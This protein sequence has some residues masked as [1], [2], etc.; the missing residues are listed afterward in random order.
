MSPKPLPEIVLRP[1]TAADAPACGQIY[2]D[3]FTPSTRLTFPPDFPSPEVAA[4]M[5]SW[6]RQVQAAFHKRSASLY[7]GLG[8]DIREPTAA[9]RK[10]GAFLFVR[11]P[12]S[13]EIAA[14]R[15][16][17][18]VIC[19]HGFSSDRRSAGGARA[20]IDNF[21]ASNG[22]DDRIRAAGFGRGG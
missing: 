19:N 15:P 18:S 8:F 5:L 11:G 4:G 10:D 6:L 7:A 12:G 1:A 13:A 9:A 16:P 20:G 17:P 22:H 3:A 14:F 21:A 2:Y